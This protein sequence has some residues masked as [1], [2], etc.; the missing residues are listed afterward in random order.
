MGE[1]S[2]EGKVGTTE[3]LFPIIEDL[4]FLEKARRSGEVTGPLC[5]LRLL[6]KYKRINK[7]GPMPITGARMAAIGTER[8]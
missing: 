5:L 4:K 6:H 3:I 1:V 7:G 2:E 8:C